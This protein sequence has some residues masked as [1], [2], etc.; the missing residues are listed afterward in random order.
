MENKNNI[1]IY[2]SP[3]NQT[4]VRVQFQDET[5][6]LSLNQIVELFDS[7]KANISEHLSHIFSD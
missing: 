2:T 1:V 3:D 5:A 4:E 7:S 6:W